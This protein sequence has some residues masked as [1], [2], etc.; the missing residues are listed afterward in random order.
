MATLYVENVPHDIYRA[1]RQRARMRRRSMAAEVLAL[2]EENIP[3]QRELTARRQ[4]LRAVENMHAKNMHA[5]KLHSRSRAFASTE[6][7]LRRDR[8]R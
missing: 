2:L 5:K 4:F 8:A 1:L 6:Q 3:T 7:M